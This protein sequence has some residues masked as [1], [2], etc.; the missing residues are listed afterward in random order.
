MKRI[1]ISILF[2]SIAF[3]G[4]AV[5]LGYV[6]AKTDLFTS[7]IKNTDKEVEKENY[8]EAIELCKKM[9]KKWKDSSETIDMLLNHEAVDRIGV[10]FSKMR[11]FIENKRIDLY[12]AESINAKKELA[13]IKASEC[14]SIENIL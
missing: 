5:Q 4:S 1:Y 7:L 3:I 13:Y 9:D 11:S 2:L 6:S 10:N 14:F 8:S 12:Y